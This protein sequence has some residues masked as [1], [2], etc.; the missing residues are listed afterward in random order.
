M[1]RGKNE[2]EGR[3]VRGGSTAPQ[4][5]GTRRK[6]AQGRTHMNID[7]PLADADADQL[8]RL[9]TPKKYVP[10]QSTIAEEKLV[11]KQQP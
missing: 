11:K 3:E 1:G 6:N 9:K 8:N 5:E 2:V 10:T 7:N 4:S